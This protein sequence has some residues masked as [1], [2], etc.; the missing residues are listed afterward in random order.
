V[1]TRQSLLDLRET[2]SRSAPHAEL[3]LSDFGRMLGRAADRYPY[4][5]SYV[6]KLLAGT[7]PI[8]PQVA[9]AVRVLMVSAAVLEER[10]EMGSGP[11]FR[12][13]PVNKLKSARSSGADWQ[14]L[15]VQDAEVRA[16]VDA[17][18]DLITSG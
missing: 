3:S 9:R 12:G 18:I 1:I 6:S 2:L 7:K 8:T 5:R 13:E 17:L 10:E 14:G 4:S 11:T 15:Y 16:F